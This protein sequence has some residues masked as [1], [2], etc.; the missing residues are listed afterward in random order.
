MN[1]TFFV[2]FKHYE[3]IKSQ[4]Q[5]IYG[6]KLPCLLF[7]EA[8]SQAE[9]TYYT[10]KVQYSSKYCFLNVLFHLQAYRFYTGKKIK[11]LS[12][13][14]L[15]YLSNIFFIYNFVFFPHLPQFRAP[16]LDFSLSVFVVW[17]WPPCRF[18][19]VSC[20]RLFARCSPHEGSSALRATSQPRRG[21]RQIFLHPVKNTYS[22]KCFFIKTSKKLKI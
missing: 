9:F 7:Y 22:Y 14:F 16:E 6:N 10:T 13:F 20:L 3:N 17:T 4:K 2:L 1:A 15:Y 5:T 8:S 19:P 18:V 21:H 12:F 11:N